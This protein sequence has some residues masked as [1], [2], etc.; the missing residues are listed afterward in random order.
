M[1]RIFDLKTLVCVCVRASES[2]LKTQDPVKVTAILMRLSGV[3]STETRSECVCAAAATCYSQH[4]NQ[5]DWLPLFSVNE[6]K[7]T[8]RER[9]NQMRKEQA[10]AAAAATTTN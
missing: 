8:N 2:C 3:I 4:E 5:T 1:K 10:T 9:E 6:T 7:Y